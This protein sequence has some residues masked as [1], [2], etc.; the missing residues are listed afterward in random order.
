MQRASN[1]L[2]RFRHIN[3]I[4]CHF[5]KEGLFG[6]KKTKSARMHKNSFLCFYR[7]VIASYH[8][9]TS[10]LFSIKMKKYKNYGYSDFLE[11]F[12]LNLDSFNFYF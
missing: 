9:N 3:L 8:S 11:F 2:A 6:E 5:S 4:T 10:S 1:E 12:H 7:L